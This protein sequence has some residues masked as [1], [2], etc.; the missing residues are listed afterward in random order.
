MGFGTLLSSLAALVFSLALVLG[1]AW[2]AIFLLRK[3]QDRSLGPRDAERANDRPLR[4]IRALPLGQRERVVLIEVG[5]ETMLLGIGAGGV[6]LLSR[7]DAGG[8]V[9]AVPAP[10]PAP[11]RP[12]PLGGDW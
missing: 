3:W 10:A 1:L 4:F 11:P 7:W 12:A 8:A 5:E 2:G 9:T 6:T